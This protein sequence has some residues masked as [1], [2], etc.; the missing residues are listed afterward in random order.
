MTRKLDTTPDATL[1]RQGTTLADTVSRILA[2]WAQ[3]DDAAREAGAQ[4]YGAEAVAVLAALVTA[5]EDAG[6]STFTREHAAAVVAHL[7]P[8][9]TWARNVAGAMALVTGGERAALAV[10]CM[11]ANVG[12]AVSAMDANDALSTLKGPKTAAFARNLLGDRDAVTVDVWAARIAFGDSV[13]DPEKALGRTGVYAAVAHA[14]RVAAASV[15]VTPETMQATTWVV[16]RNGRA[17]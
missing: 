11:S 1:A 6:R 13:G 7:S 5:A 14:Y 12:R 3:A 10:G 15:G 9:T 8:R 2:V 16:A 17:A 4:W